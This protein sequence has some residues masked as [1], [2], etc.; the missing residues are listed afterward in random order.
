MWAQVTSSVLRCIEPE[1]FL[2][3]LKE[4]MKDRDALENTKE[5]REKNQSW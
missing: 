1:I 5:V 3:K 2:L 4:E